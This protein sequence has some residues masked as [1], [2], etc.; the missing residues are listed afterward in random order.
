MGSA[1]FGSSL[2][3]RDKMSGFMR[4]GSVLKCCQDFARDLSQ[5]SGG[6]L[7]FNHYFPFSLA[8]ALMTSLMVSVV[9]GSIIAAPQVSRLTKNRRLVQQLVGAV[10]VCLP[11]LIGSFQAPVYDEPKVSI[12]SILHRTLTLSSTLTIE[13]AVPVGWACL[14]PRMP[15]CLSRSDSGLIFAY[16]F[17][18]QALIA[19]RPFAVRAIKWASAK[20]P[21]TLPILVEML[22]LLCVL[23]LLTTVIPAFFNFLLEIGS[24][25]YARWR[26][27]RRSDVPTR[28]SRFWTAPV[29][30]TTR[31]RRS[32]EARCLSMTMLLYVLGAFMPVFML[33]LLPGRDFQ[34]LE[35]LAGQS[36][37]LLPAYLPP[38]ARRH[39]AHP[40][41]RQSL[42]R[43]A[44]ECKWDQQAEASRWNDTQ[45]TPPVIRAVY[46]ASRSPGV[47]GITQANKNDCR[48]GAKGTLG[49]AVAAFTSKAAQL[50]QLSQSEQK[51]LAL[52]ECV[53]QCN[54]C[55]R[56]R[57]ISFSHTFKDC[58]WFS[59]CNMAALRKVHGNF[60]T[61]PV[62]DAIPMALSSAGAK[63][64]AAMRCTHNDSRQSCN[65]LA[66]SLQ[67]AVQ[68]HLSN[69]SRLPRRPIARD[70]QKLRTVPIQTTSKRVKSGGR[71][72]KKKASSSVVGR[73]VRCATPSMPTSCISPRMFAKRLCVWLSRDSGQFDS[74][75]KR[76][77]LSE[78]AYR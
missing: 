23:L 49:V 32:R 72:T 31:S 18:Q 77:S 10:L 14:L 74:L 38:H 47:C 53:A 70:K 30:E 59:K 61:V 8:V 22:I 69:A 71:A 68:S 36:D 56:C 45:L 42:K 37:P 75:F 40:I 4:P 67:N 34:T 15:T 57:F 20:A 9:V 27:H 11:S 21:G 19:V 73:K 64:L 26:G 65:Y 39:S 51:W 62:M 78:A 3:S 5:R 58:S 50:K 1:R 29:D 48:A 28:F 54:M 41:V 7:V 16:L 76:Q 12:G 35:I 63:G 52:S 55:D 6:V 44:G 25:Y 2:C 33:A 43:L 24:F 46:N 60:F 13:L 17:H 66:T